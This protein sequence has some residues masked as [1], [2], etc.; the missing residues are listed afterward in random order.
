[1]NE[2]PYDGSGGGERFHIEG[3]KAM[4]LLRLDDAATSQ[5][6]LVTTR[7]WHIQGT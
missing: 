2:C 1:M 4:G 7:S 6:R 5:G 3:E